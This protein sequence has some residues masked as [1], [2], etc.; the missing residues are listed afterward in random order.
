MSAPGQPISDGAAQSQIADPAPA[1]APTEGIQLNNVPDPADPTT[2]KLPVVLYDV[3]TVADS[4]RIVTCRNPAAQVDVV[5]RLNRM[6]LDGLIES[7]DAGYMC[8]EARSVTV[9]LPYN[10]A[11]RISSDSYDVDTAAVV[12]I[13]NA[14]K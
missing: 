7:D 10:P 1:P 11:T 3:L 9:T 13:L 2:V 8:A 5:T 12:L 4:R 14:A 6:V